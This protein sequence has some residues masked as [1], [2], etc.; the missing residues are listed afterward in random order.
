MDEESAEEEEE[1]KTTENWK[2]LNKFYTSSF[3]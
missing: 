3:Y 1:A 2:Q